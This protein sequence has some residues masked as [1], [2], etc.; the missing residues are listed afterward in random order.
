VAAYDQNNLKTDQEDARN[1]PPGARIKR[2]PRHDQFDKVVPSGPEFVKPLRGKMQIATDRIGNR[3]GFVVVVKASS[4]APALVAAQ[5]DQV[6]ADH[7]A[8]T[9]PAK[10][11]DDEHRRPAFRKRAAVNK[12]TK[13]DR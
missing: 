2:E 6:C 9:E 12:G 13:K 10:K 1:M 8:K 4:I 11:P 7:D 3:L 5:F